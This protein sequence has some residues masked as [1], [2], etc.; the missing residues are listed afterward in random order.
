MQEAVRGLE[1]PF[2]EP[3]EEGLQAVVEAG[4]A[5]R[6]G[7]IR[8]VGDWDLDEGTLATACWLLARLGAAESVPALLRLLE[9][10]RT[11]T[12]ARAQAAIT[13]GQ[14]GD[15]ATAVRLAELLGREADLILR[16]VVVNAIGHLGNTDVAGALLRIL[17]DLDEEPALRGEAAEALGNLK[18]RGREVVAALVTSLDDPSPDVRFF[19]AFA[20]GV[21]GTRAVLPEL[22]KVA[23]ADE[24]VAEPWGSVAVEA[25]T[26][27]D[28][29]TS[30]VRRRGP[31]S[32][33]AAP[34][35]ATS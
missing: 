23:A 33:P 21:V 34:P 13:L 24:G 32:R 10:E 6:D 17:R 11:S 14:V 22:E 18:A 4:A 15:G 35:A 28:A 5:D 29:I 25:K 3:V 27:I 8:L 20:L 19:S 30:R 2:R 1:P 26:A 7:L 12:G 16:Q 31:R 9:D